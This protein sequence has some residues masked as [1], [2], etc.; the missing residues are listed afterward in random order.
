MI[1]K[2]FAVTSEHNTFTLVHLIKS[3][4]FILKAKYNEKLKIVNTLLHRSGLAH[5]HP[6]HIN[7]S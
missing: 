7:T 1:R 4:A 3:P 2:Q 5:V 6:D